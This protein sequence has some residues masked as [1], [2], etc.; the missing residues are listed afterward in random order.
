M[1]LLGVRHILLVLAERIPISS[2]RGEY[3]YAIT[4]SVLEDSS[5]NIINV[6]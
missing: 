4:V 6:S 5:E 3:G 1:E 2:S